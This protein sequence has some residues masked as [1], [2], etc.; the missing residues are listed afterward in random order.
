MELQE[1]IVAKQSKISS[2]D[3]DPLSPRPAPSTADTG[4][5]HDASGNRKRAHENDSESDNDGFKSNSSSW[6]D[7][8]S[9]DD[10]KLKIDVPKKKV[11]KKR[12]KSP[13]RRGIKE[14]NIPEHVLAECSSKLLD[15]DQNLDAKAKSINWGR[16][17]VKMVLRAIVQ[18]EEMMIMLRNAGVATG[19]KQPQQ[20]PKMTRAMTKKVVEA[21]GE[22]PFIVPPATPV[23]ED[24]ARLFAEDLNEED[25]D[26]EYNP[27]ADT[28]L[29]DD[30]DSL[31]TSDQS[32]AG[33][34]VTVN[35]DS[36]LSLCSSA[37]ST[38]TSCHRPTPDQFKRPFRAL[39]GDRL[40]ASRTLD[41]DSEP[42]AGAGRVYSTRSR[43]NI[44]HQAIEE[45]EQQ[46]VPP[47]IT[48]DMYELPNENDDNVYLEFLKTFWSGPVDKD[49]HADEMEV[50]DDP[51]YVF[52]QDVADK[53]TKD[54]EELRYDK[55]TKITKKEHADLM[56]ELH[57]IGNKGVEDNI[58]KKKLIK[59]KRT[60]NLADAIFDTVKE[61]S[62]KAERLEKNNTDNVEKSSEE[63]VPQISDNERLELSLQFQQH[64]QL[65]TQMSLLSSHS[66]AWVG[67]RAQCDTMMSDILTQSLASHNSVAG[68]PNLVTSMAVISEWDKVGTDP[69]V[70]TKNKN[71]VKHKKRYRN[72]CLAP[73]LIEFMSAKSVFYFPLLL[74]LRGL[75]QDE[76]RIMWTKSEDNLLAF[77]MRETFPLV[78]KNNLV[79]LSFAL[80]KRYMRAKTA[81]Q[82][83]ARIKNLK[84]RDNGDNP[85]VRYIKRY[86]YQPPRELHT[87]AEVGNGTKTMMEMFVSGSRKDFEE[88]WQ[89][90]LTDIVRRRSRHFVPISPKTKAP[91]KPPLILSCAAEVAAA[92]PAQRGAALLC[93]DGNNVTPV[94]DTDTPPD[95]QQPEPGTRSPIKKLI[96]SS[97]QFN[98]SPLKAA[99]ERIIKKYAVI[100]PHKRTGSSLLKSPL[101]KP[102]R[103]K[104]LTI[105]PKPVTPSRKL[106]GLSLK[107]ASTPPNLNLN[108]SPKSPCL[109][110]PSLDDGDCINEVDTPTHIGKRKSRHQKEAE[111]TLALVGPL[112]TA[113]EKEAREAKESTEIFQEIMKVVSDSSEKRLKFAEIMSGAASEGTVQTYKDLSLLVEGHPDVQE[114]LLDLLSEDQAASVSREVYWLHQQRHNMKKFILKLNLA[115]RHR[116]A[117]HA[118]VLRELD[119]L[120]SEPGLTPDTLRAVAVKLFKH[121]QH[122]LD[123][124]LVLVPGVEPPESML[125]SPELLQSPDSASDNSGGDS[126]TQEV[127]VVPKSPESTK[128]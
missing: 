61:H 55:A 35:T 24:L 47:D 105:S 97:H 32:G 60:I 65:L 85:V 75:N 6:E 92:S 48:P 2:Q 15:M 114:M 87:W 39:C 104:A 27:E 36:R 5:S 66:P 82:I 43:V 107:A 38:P 57:E 112:E 106:P 123:Q 29:S 9:S 68:Q 42:E 109:Q 81:V 128:S 64:I 44:R 80:Q 84:E 117:D 110:S 120:C 26:P 77:A 1:D 12:H 99:S 94:S 71:S 95:T 31:F 122:L 56:A 21:G 14:I 76:L 46:F 124:F 45:L 30:E 50:D 37:V 127:V 25:N 89:N 115:Y 53:E 16:K 19:E 91:P 74:P 17:Q 86:E 49:K 100:S 62:D 102:F 125:P 70:V 7:Q 4:K 3:E 51:E 34:P 79:E 73:Q 108:F 83:L 101:K 11:L 18:S 119:T 103:R 20:E 126:D 10:A 116:P 96:L 98:K 72:F 8:E 63:S 54:H 33:T 118:R 121:N 67:V 22:V 28:N 59:E 41:F 23:K 111:L 40:Q 13:T 52:C 93:V 113:E 69:T 58:N 78:K 88:K 90:N